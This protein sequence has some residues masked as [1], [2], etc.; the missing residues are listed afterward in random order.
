MPHTEEVAA[1]AEEHHR[2]HTVKI[3]IDRVEKTSPTPTTGS[4]CIR[5]ALCRTDTFSSG[6]SRDIVTTKSSPRP[7]LLFTSPSGNT[8]TA[9]KGS[10][11]QGA[12]TK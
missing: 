11:T 4:A 2:H 10:S 6:R 8:S 3:Y 1:H 5:S 7:K 12:S 9:L